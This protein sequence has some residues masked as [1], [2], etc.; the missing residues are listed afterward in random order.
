[1]LLGVE[2]MKAQRTTSGLTGRKPY[3]R[4]CLFY[5]SVERAWATEKSD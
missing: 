3:Q 4:L 2:L 1:M 5:P